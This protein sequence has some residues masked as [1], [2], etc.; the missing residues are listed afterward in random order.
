[1]STFEALLL[2]LLILMLLVGGKQGFSNFMALLIN[3]VLMVLAVILI[4]GGFNAIG[5]AVVI[6]FI[7][8]ATTIFLSTAD[9]NV[10][11]TAFV[12]SLLVAATLLSA[13][14]R[15]MVVAVLV[16]VLVLAVIVI[17]VSLAHVQ[18]FGTEDSEELEGYNLLIGVSFQN[19]LIATAL[20]STLGAIAEAAVAVAAG[21]AELGGHATAQGLTKMS[22]EII[23]TA[24][25]T[26]FF[27][28]FGGFAGLFIWFTQLKYPFWQVLNNKIFAGELIQVLFSMIAVTLTVPL[29]MW[30]VKTRE[31]GNHA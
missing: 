31:K 26:L 6:A 5:V 17:G 2:A 16:T 21:M 8:L 10:A 25:N 23:G 9:S 13:V 20:F 4:A 19:I 15:K 18:G 1:M 11:A 28:F 12:A 24:L 27:G 29:T 7:V 22:G 3:L 14:D 30:V